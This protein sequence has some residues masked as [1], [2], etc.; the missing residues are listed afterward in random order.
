MFENAIDYQFIM[1]DIQ[2]C[3]GYAQLIKNVAVN[4]SQNDKKSKEESR[5]LE[6]LKREKSKEELRPLYDNYAVAATYYQRA[7]EHS[8]LLSTSETNGKS[9]RISEAL[10][11]LSEATEM[12]KAWGSPYALLLLSTGSYTFRDVLV[13][14]YSS[15]FN[16]ILNDYFKSDIEPIPSKVVQYVYTLIASRETSP[17]TE[18]VDRYIAPFRHRRVGILGLYVHQ[19]LNVLQT[20]NRND[21]SVQMAMIPILIAYDEALQTA[22]LNKYHFRRLLM[23]FH[24]VNAEVIGLLLRIRQQMP[25]VN[26]LERSPI[27]PLAKRFLRQ[28]ITNL[29]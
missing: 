28:L 24:P 17:L 1:E 15:D 19:I 11:Y 16:D 14:S 4:M 29:A 25:G 22:M 2:Y 7:A 5:P 9:T 21:E 18:K 6:E 20:L 8:L 23:N 3:A 10:K 27:S 26:V 12:S 13:V